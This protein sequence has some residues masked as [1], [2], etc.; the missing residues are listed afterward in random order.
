MVS[1]EDNEDREEF[2]DL[3]QGIHYFLDTFKIVELEQTY[4]PNRS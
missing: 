2:Y 4:E 3:G 1:G